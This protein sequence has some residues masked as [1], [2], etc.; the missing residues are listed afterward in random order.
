VEPLAAVHLVEGRK[1]RV[2]GPM[3]NEVML[4]P[5]FAYVFTFLIALGLSVVV[6]QLTMLVTTVY[7]HRHLA[8][9][10]VELRPEVRAA[11]RFLIWI[12]SGMKPRQW[13]QVHRYH[14]AA[15]DTPDDPH[16]PRNFGGGRRGARYVL[17]HNGSLY[18][19][20]TRD[21]RLAEKYR[22]LTADRWDHRLFDHGQAGV[23]LG[24]ALAGT[25]MGLI[26]HA[27]VGGWIG[28]IVG[29]AAGVAAAGL[30]FASYLLAGG[31][32]N[33]YG[34]AAT[35]GQ[36]ASGYSRNMP[37]IAWLTGG[38]GWHR[39]HHAAE[40]SPRLG[41]GHQLDFGWIAISALRHLRLA[42]VTARGT[43]GLSRLRSLSGTA[44]S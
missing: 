32:I 28:A 16:S 19:H 15:E 38:E 20:A 22:D 44:L 6:T 3:T 36:P 12:S 35:V 1:R 23:W 42:R 13:A 27:L 8:H 18:T 30:H 34:H 31:V 29:I 39:N 41:L 14:H 24:V 4:S 33:G 40:N 43:A 11:S 9:H 25:A 21:P 37:V 5:V 26:G 7:L 2:L 17:W 10:S